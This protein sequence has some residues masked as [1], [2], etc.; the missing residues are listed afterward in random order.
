LRTIG[1]RQH[2][3]ARTHARTHANKQGQ[4]HK[5]VGAREGRTKG[6]RGGGGR[7]PDP[8]DRSAPSPSPHEEGKGQ[9]GKGPRAGAG[10]PA[11]TQTHNDRTLAPARV[12]PTEDGPSTV[13]GRARSDA[14]AKEA[15]V[16]S[17]S[18][19]LDSLSP[20]GPRPATGQGLR[21]S[22]PEGAVTGEQEEE[23]DE[24]EAA[25][26]AAAVPSTSPNPSL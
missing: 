12:G 20:T 25:A 21:V 11:T 15:V 3:H 6:S 26:A 16:S 10:R 18:A 1:R 22:R 23:E 5:G 13:R 14:V 8:E 2:M 19:R 4:G 24:E 9:G 7:G 17:H